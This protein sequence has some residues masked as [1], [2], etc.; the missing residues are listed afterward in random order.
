MSPRKVTSVLD[1]G[2]QENR[3][4]PSKVQ[5]NIVLSP[6]VKGKILKTLVKLKNTGQQEQTIKI[7]RV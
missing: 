5:S 1:Y 3:L 6:E 4:V 7:P 2:T